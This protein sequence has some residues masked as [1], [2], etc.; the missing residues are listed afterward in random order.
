MNWNQT[1]NKDWYPTLSLRIGAHSLDDKE[2][3][4]TGEII[5]GDFDTGASGIF[6][7]YEL[8]KKLGIIK[9][10]VNFTTVN[11]F[12][13]DTFRSIKA[14]LKISLIGSSG[15]SQ[16]VSIPCDA[17]IDFEHSPFTKYFRNRMGSPSHRWIRTAFWERPDLRRMTL[18]WPSTT[19]P[20]KGSRD[21]WRSPRPCLLISR[22]Y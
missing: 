10:F 3:K 16:P 20:W 2:F 4:N 9:D 7:S 11:M 13:G 8:L 14:V 5:V 12:S 15:E 1:E 18:S 21:L 19:Y 17:I 22:P 6:L